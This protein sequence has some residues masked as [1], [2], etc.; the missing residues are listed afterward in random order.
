[1]GEVPGRWRDAGGLSQRL[2]GA[3]DGWS[4]A[5]VASRWC[6]MVRGWVGLV[7]GQGTGEGAG[8]TLPVAP[9]TSEHS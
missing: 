6:H 5:K 2:G 3:G 8:V 9:S 7:E 4:P 1:M